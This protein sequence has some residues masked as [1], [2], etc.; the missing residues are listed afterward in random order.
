MTTSQMKEY[1]GVVFN[2]KRETVVIRAKNLDAAKAQMRK[3]YGQEREGDVTHWVCGLAPA[4]LT[5]HPTRA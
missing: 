3:K 2:D 5:G 1:N 4:S